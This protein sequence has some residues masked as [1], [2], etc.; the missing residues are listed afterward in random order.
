MKKFTLIIGTALIALSPATAQKQIIKKANSVRP[1]LVKKSAAK[2]A[3]P[4]P[5]SA[6][7]TDGAIMRPETAEAYLYMEGEWLPMSMS[8]YSYNKDGFITKDI[9]DEDGILTLTTY[10]YDQNNKPLSVIV[11]TDETG[12][13][14]AYIK[15]SKKT[16]T[17]DEKVTDFTTSNEEFVWNDVNSAWTL[18]GNCFKR[19]V[20]RN[21]DGNISEIEVSVIYN[22]AYT[23][24][25]RTLI[26]Y[27]PNT[28]QANEWA[29]QQIEVDYETGT[30]SWGIPTTYK[31]LKWHKTNGQIVK[32]LEESLLGDNCIEAYEVYEADELLA[33]CKT[34]YIDG[35]DDFSQEITTP[36]GAEM[37]LHTYVSDDAFGSYTET[38]IDGYDEDGDGTIS[39]MEKFTSKII[40][41]VNDQG[42]VILSEEY[43][44][45][46]GGEME[47][48]GGTKYEYT[49][50]EATGEVASQTE[51]FYNVDLETPAYEPM[52]K[53]EYSK[54]VSTGIDTA[55]QT[56]V[57]PRTVFDL[58]GRPMGT[59]T[60]GLPAGIYLVK[61]SGKT[62]KI[63]KK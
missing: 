46:P 56:P 40:Y 51:Y 54:F 18:Q 32:S 14:D 23:P 35:K 21:A 38:I 12:M 4:T 29:F 52:F 28:K 36:D 22:G 31:N 43:M 26:S 60:D 9:T 3:T 45:E 39:E 7:R 37:Q 16:K 6:L 20:K 49:F 17:Y 5:L 44:Q 57:A 25:E 42:Y 15:T 47:L 34:T 27:D 41:K 59:T 50:D 58:Q 55:T 61:D 1:T 8:T 48:M 13:G 11:E 10:T 19:P 2:K 53:I 30:T 24:T 63:I 62:T 33:T